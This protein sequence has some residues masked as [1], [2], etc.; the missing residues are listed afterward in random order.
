MVETTSNNLNVEIKTGVVVLLDALGI[1]TATTK[2]AV[3]FI[4]I[5]NSILP[6]IH[7]VKHLAAQSFKFTDPGNIYSF[8][9]TVILTW[10]TNEND[11]LLQVLYV[12]STIS[13]IIINEG[14][15]RGILWRGAIAVG[16]F[17]CDN[18][19]TTILG[20]A[21]ADAASW[22]EVADWFG[23]IATPHTGFYAELLCNEF[24]NGTF[25]EGK[26]KSAPPEM[27]FVKYMVPIKN[28]ISTEMYAVPWPHTII[29]DTETKEPSYIKLMRSFKKIYYPK[30]N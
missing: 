17:I 13:N 23:V 10:E 24:K 26:M 28:S 6:F 19:N 29:S 16:D 21:V 9:D 25:F 20:P 22:Y 2:E 27:A 1:S 3:N 4:E 11:K 7:Q 14:L 15:E 5:I 18:N 30:R 12:A 8:A